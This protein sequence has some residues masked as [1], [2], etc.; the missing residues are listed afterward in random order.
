VPGFVEAQQVARA[1]AGEQEAVQ[2]G[3]AG[4][5]EEERVGDAEHSPRPGVDDAPMAEDGHRVARMTGGDAGEG[6]AEPSYLSF[7]IGKNPN[8][9]VRP[10][11][12]VT[13]RH[14]PIAP[15]TYRGWGVTDLDN[16]SAVSTWKYSAPHNVQRW[17]S[18][19]E[20]PEGGT[21]ST[22]CHQTEDGVDGFFLRQADLDVMSPVEAEANRDLIVPD[23][24]PSTW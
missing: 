2:R 15:D 20:V 22:A 17:T 3:V 18:R 4:L 21:C 6:L 7:K 10:Y 23:G 5:E 8:P 12:Y 1:A 16:F 9:D 11:E 19:T 13:L 14:I 24:S